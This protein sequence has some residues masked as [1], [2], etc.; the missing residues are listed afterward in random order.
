LPAG[1]EV[2]LHI[3]DE[4][5]ILGSEAHKVVC[6]SYLQSMGNCPGAGVGKDGTANRFT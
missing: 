4:E 5:E 6:F 3:D 1:A 2:I